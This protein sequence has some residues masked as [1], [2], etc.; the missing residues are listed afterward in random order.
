MIK[1]VVGLNMH[2]GPWTGQLDRSTFTSQQH[3]FFGQFNLVTVH[4]GLMTIP[5]ASVPVYSG[6]ISITLQSNWRPE[7]R[8]LARERWG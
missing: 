8:G 4:L 1:Y 6:D 2:V 5:L 7:G 3:I